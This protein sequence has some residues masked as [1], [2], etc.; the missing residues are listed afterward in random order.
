MCQQA[1]Q[2]TTGTKTSPNSPQI[3]ATA[4]WQ[5]RG[6]AGGIQAGWQLLPGWAQRRLMHPWST[7]CHPPSSITRLPIPKNVGEDRRHSLVTS[8]HFSSLGLLPKQGWVNRDSQRWQWQ[9]GVAVPA[10]L[11][12]GL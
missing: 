10:P 11:R 7:L 5:D 8:P 12:A 2:G 4:P 3:A 6:A 1:L 9:G